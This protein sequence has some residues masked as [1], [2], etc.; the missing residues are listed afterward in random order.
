[1]KNFFHLKSTQITIHL[2][3]SPYDE[4]KRFCVSH[5]LAPKLTPI[6][7]TPFELFFPQR[8]R[9]NWKTWENYILTFFSIFHYMWEF[10]MLIEPSLIFA[11]GVAWLWLCD[12][13]ILICFRITSSLA[14]WNVV[15]V[16]FHPHLPPLL[17]PTWLLWYQ[18]WRFTN[19]FVFVLCN[20]IDTV[21]K[22]LLY[23]KHENI[24]THFDIL[25]Y[26]QHS[27]FP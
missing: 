10:S 4:A 12:C 16:S 23:D 22:S 5:S 11:R 14:L 2:L 1:M 6:E 27:G 9:K 15:I 26:N 3:N 7:S 13:V 8:A 17:T 24:K 25:L 21:C 18:N 20:K 19:L